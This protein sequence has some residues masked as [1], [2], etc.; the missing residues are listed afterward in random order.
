MR[1]I[2]PAPDADGI[3][4]VSAAATLPFPPTEFGV[5][6]DLYRE[7]LNGCPSVFDLDIW[8]DAACTLTLAELYGGVLHPMVLVADDV[9]LV[10]FATNSLDIA[11][12]LYATGDGPVQLTTGTTLPTG[13]SLLT[14]YYI[15]VD[16]AGT[17]SLA[18]SFANALAGTVVT[19][20]DVGVGVH[21]ISD[22]VNTSRMYWHSFGLLGD[23]KDGTITLG[24]ALARIE[25][26]D[27]NPLVRAYA[28]SATPTAGNISATLYPIIER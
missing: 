1:P 5:I 24:V 15:I 14:D 6:P 13:L 7:V 3:A 19:F 2:F 23:A 16:N 22:T 28:M 11:G 9:D 12:H 4:L 17:I 10:D 21:T 27:H 8:C 26:F 25:R 18:T 20:S